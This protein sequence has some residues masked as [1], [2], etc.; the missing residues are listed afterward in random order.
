[1]HGEE[2][3]WFDPEKAGITIR[4]LF[5]PFPQEQSDVNQIPLL[6]EQLSKNIDRTR[7]SGHNVIFT[8]IA[9]RALQDHPQYATPSIVQ[10]IS[11]LIARFN[12]RGP[13]RGYYGEERGWILGNDMS[14]P[15]D[16]DYPL[17]TDQLDLV[18]R[19]MN[20]LR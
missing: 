4:E 15:A 17:Y 13:G 8:A 11:K 9:I 6:L 7:E 20:E 19:T 1:M 3:I 2:I 18:D 12:D 14:L 10:G 16:D 5:E